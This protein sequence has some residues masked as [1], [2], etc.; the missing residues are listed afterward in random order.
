MRRGPT[1]VPPLQHGGSPTPALRV[2]RG[3]CR[4]RRR[5]QRR[6]CKCCRVHTS[7]YII[8]ALQILCRK[9]LIGEFVRGIAVC[10]QDQL[11][12]LAPKHVLYRTDHSA[13]CLPLF[14]LA[15]LTPLLLAHTSLPLSAY[16]QQVADGKR[17]SFPHPL[18]RPHPSTASTC[19]HLPAGNGVHST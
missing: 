13:L 2:P 4:W 8:V 16:S 19:S 18:Q 10:S 1:A 11:Q 9:F 6:T 12:C 3:R 5:R 7:T 15:S 17:V 14:S